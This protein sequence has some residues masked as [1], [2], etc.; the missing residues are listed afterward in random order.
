[1]FIAHHPFSAICLGLVL[2]AG[3][4]HAANGPTPDIS[5]VLDGRFTSYSNG[6]YYILP[7]FMLGKSE[8]DDKGFHLGRTELLFNSDIDDMFYGRVTTALTDREGSTDVE[9]EEAYIETL[10]LGGGTMIRAGRFFSGI[11]YLNDQHPHSWDF[12]DAP[13]VYRALFGD[14]LNDD[15]IQLNWIAPAGLKLKLGAELTHGARYPAGD[16]S[17]DGN[18]A[19]ALFAKIGGG[20]V[21]SRYWQLGISYW[22][23]DVDGRTSQA[24][25]QTGVLSA[26]P[27]FS[28]DSSVWGCDAVLKWAPGGKAAERNFKLQAEYFVRNERGT[29]TMADGT[30][31]PESSS[32]DSRQ[33]G[34]YAQAV[35]Q[36]KPGWRTGLRYDQ[37]GTHN[38][39]P[40][41]VV[42]M[43]SGLD[44]EGQHP[45]NKTLMLDYSYSAYSRLRLQY[46]LDESY[47]QNDHIIMLQYVMSLGY[48]GAHP[49]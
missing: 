14:Q 24:H 41:P 42:L 6:S 15:G 43:A 33:V 5:L 44:S 4:V 28:G 18:G 8:R 17:N 1:M 26:I 46:S 31:T 35:F 3:V 2:G 34:W 47:E 21:S 48:H 20:A 22:R 7:G 36:F 38:S 19:Y 45:R 12:T 25:L 40:N 37:L 10:R 49:F 27:T 30:A 39:V 11:G 32:Y 23:A 13:L 9:L 16:A 29:V